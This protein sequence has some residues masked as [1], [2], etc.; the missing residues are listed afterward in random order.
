M[1]FSMTTMT[2]TALGFTEFCIMTLS[3]TIIFIT[4]LSMM[5]PSIMTL[6]GNKVETNVILNVPN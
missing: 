4:T 1:T 6:T 3:I 5:T 2:L